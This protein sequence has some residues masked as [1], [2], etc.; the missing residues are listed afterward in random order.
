MHGHRVILGDI[1]HAA[2]I[3]RHVARVIRHPVTVI[4]SHGVERQVHCARA[5]RGVGGERDIILVEGIVALVAQLVGNRLPPGI[6]LVMVEQRTHLHRETGGIGQDNVPQ[7]VVRDIVADG[8]DGIG[9]VELHVVVHAGFSFGRIGLHIETHLIFHEAAVVQGHV[10]LVGAGHRQGRIV[11]NRGRAHP[12]YPPVEP[13]GRVTP[14]Y[15]VDGQLQLEA[16]QHAVVLVL[17]QIIVQVLG[18][19]LLRRVLHVDSHAVEQ[20]FALR[21][22]LGRGTR[23]HHCQQHSCGN[24]GR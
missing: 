8:T 23:G 4:G 17:A 15:V 20:Q 24:D 1:D 13:V 12:L 5:C 10:Q 18:V 19:D 7:R 9:L 11:D 3:E 16:S 22:M 14:A 6:E 21:H 2:H